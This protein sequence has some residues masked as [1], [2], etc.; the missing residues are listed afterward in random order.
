MKT[1]TYLK[2][3]KKLVFLLSA[4]PFVAM[5][6]TLPLPG[7]GGDIVG[8]IQTAVVRPGDNFSIIARRYDMGYTELVEA[9]PDVDPDHPKQGAVLII[10]SEF[11]LPNTPH[12]GIVVNISEMRLFY[13][14]KGAHEVITYPVG[15]G[16]EGEETPLGVLRVGQ[17]ITKPTWYAPESIRKMR[18]AQGVFLPKVVPPGPDNPLGDYALRLSN[19]NYLIHGTN[20]PLGG[21][22]RRSSSGCVRMYPEDI[23]QLFHTVANGANVYIVD[24]PIK[25]GWADNKLYLESHVAVQENPDSHAGNVRPDVAKVIEAMLKDHPADV[26]WNKALAIA[27]EEQGLPQ[28]V[29]QAQTQPAPPAELAD[30]QSFGHVQA[31]SED[32]T[33][34][35]SKH[36]QSA[37]EEQEQNQLPNEL[38]NDEN[39]DRSKNDNVNDEIKM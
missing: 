1:I 36:V 28:V 27:R 16:R 3:A 25:A 20:D 35:S 18:A 22:G 6:L 38:A 7:N 11:I 9:N 31:K 23:E 12:D 21:I 29:G 15:I 19:P 8:Q 32:V 2:L 33:D 30:N 14:P 4:L 26:N 17:H 34:S 24:Q 13:F 5:A 37:G 39:D 10:P